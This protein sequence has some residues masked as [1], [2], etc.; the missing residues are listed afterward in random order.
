MKRDYYE[1]LAVPK[2]ANDRE[3]KKAYRKLALDNHPDRNPG[4]SAAENRFKEASEAYEVLS[5]EQKRA[6]Y[7]R[8]GHEGLRGSGF[9]GFSGVEDIF[10]HFGDL[11]SEIFGGS[12]FSGGGF[13][14]RGRGAA[15]GAD[16]RHDLR[17]SFEE[18]VHGCEREIEVPRLVACEECSGSGAAK[19]TTPQTCTTCGGAGAVV[20]QQGFFTLQ[21]ACPRCR[22]RGSII[23]TV[24]EACH[25]NGRQEVAR[26]VAV[27]IPPG[28][29]SGLRLRLT[30]EGELGERSGPPGDLYVF[31]Q[32][33]PDERWQRD[34][35]DLFLERE[36]SFVQAILGTT[37]SI[38]T[39]EGER[40]IEVQPGT[41]PNAVLGISGGGVPQLRGYGRGDLV[42]KLTIT[43]PKKMLREEEDLLRQYA[44]LA[45]VSV[46]PRKKGFF[47]KIKDKL[48]GADDDS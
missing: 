9:S 23:E 2:N 11:F 7:D 48:E 1:V 17:L 15:R 4:D 10:S 46:M 37:L 30:G 45:E 38:P 43:M 26:T 20:Q 25:G 29:D 44:E 19:G 21:T 3:I 13:G 12:P 16:L 8:F 22:G 39:L 28:V 40:E 42:V 47:Q 32:V 35:A 31:L 34:G 33:E 14:G 6:T 18:A 27:K 41:Q 5:D 24:C 36:I